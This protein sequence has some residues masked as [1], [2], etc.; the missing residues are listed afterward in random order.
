MAAPAAIWIQS[1]R[2]SPRR[3]YVVANIEYREASSYN[4]PAQLNDTRAGVKWLRANASRLNLDPQ[5]IAGWGYSAGA[6]RVALAATFKEDADSRLQAVVSGGLPADLTHYPVSPIITKFIGAAYAE[7]PKTWIEAS[8]VSH[9][10][11][12]TPPMFLYHGEWDRLVYVEDSIAMKQALKRAHVPVELYL[13]S[14]SG[15]IGG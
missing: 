7:K 3:G 14:G 11:G 9:V 6:H 10:S 12:D 4:Y 5:Q 13:I 8:P 1:P 15:H 2:S